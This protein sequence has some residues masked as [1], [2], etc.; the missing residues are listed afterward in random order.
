MFCRSQLFIP[1]VL[2]CAFLALSSVSLC[3]VLRFHLNSTLPVEVSWSG[4]EEL[5]ATTQQTSIPPHLLTS[6]PAQLQQQQQQGQREGPE[7]DVGAD[8]IRALR[9]EGLGPVYGLDLSRVPYPEH[10]RRYCL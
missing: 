10:H 9:D 8:F 3:Q 1:V 7:Q 6:P 2:P 4:P 5:Q